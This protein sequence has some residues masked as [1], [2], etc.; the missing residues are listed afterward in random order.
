MFFRLREDLTG[1]LSPRTPFVCSRTNVAL[2]LEPMIQSP[3]FGANFVLPKRIGADADS[4]FSDRK[5]SAEVEVV[6]P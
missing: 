3:A 4:F 5:V 6:R 1:L 2:R